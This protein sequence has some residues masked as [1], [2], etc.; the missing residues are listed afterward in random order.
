MSLLFGAIF[1][2]CN[3]ILEQSRTVIGSLPLSLARSQILKEKIANEV[4]EY[5][6]VAQITLIK[7]KTTNLMSGEAFL[8]SPAESL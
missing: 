2:P 5:E 3:R 8:S 4:E 1:A 6:K 7:P